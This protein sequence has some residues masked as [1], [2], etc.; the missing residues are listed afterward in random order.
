MKILQIALLILSALFSTAQAADSPAPVSAPV[1]ASCAEHETS[2]G[3]INGAKITS[4]DIDQAMADA[5][6][7][8]THYTKFPEVTYV[9]RYGHYPK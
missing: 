9:P 3:C 4:K 1:V 7:Y 8:P 6:T 5:P 2:S